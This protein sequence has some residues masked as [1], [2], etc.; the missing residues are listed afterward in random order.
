MLNKIS[1]LAG[2]A[3]TKTADYI[4]GVPG[5]TRGVI[6]EAKLSYKAGTHGINARAPRLPKDEIPQEVS[7]WAKDN[8]WIFPDK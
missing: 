5:K 1:W 2:Y 4:C 7:D 8:N 6:G 3:G